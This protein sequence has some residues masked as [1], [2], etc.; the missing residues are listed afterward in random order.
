MIVVMLFLLYASQFAHGFTCRYETEHNWG[1]LHETLLVKIE[2]IGVV[3]CA[4]LL[5]IC[6]TLTSLLLL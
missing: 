4:S 6:S 2:N 3:V 5:T 1:K